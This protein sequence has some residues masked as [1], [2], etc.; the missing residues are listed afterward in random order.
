M[1]FQWTLGVK[2]LVSNTDFGDDP[3][4]LQTKT[5]SKSLMETQEPFGNKNT[6]AMV[7]ICRGNTVCY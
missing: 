7:E 1:T 4:T 6:L 3:Q 2:G 5:Y